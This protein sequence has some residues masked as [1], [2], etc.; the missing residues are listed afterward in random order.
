M[1]VRDKAK[2][3]YESGMKYKDIAEKVDV[4]INT[5]KSW[6]NRYGWSRGAPAKKKDAT[7]RKRDASHSKKVAPN[8]I[9]KL[10]KNS[11]L[12]EKQKMFC[13]Y[14]LQR[15][16]ATWAYQKAYVTS[17]EAA[18]ANGPRLIGNDR[19]KNQLNS[20]KKQLHSEM[21]VEIEDIINEYTKQSFASLGDVLDYKVHKELVMDMEGNVF[22]D[23]D[24]NPVERH[25]TDIY[26]KPSDQID[27][28]VVQDIHKGKDG[29][30]VKLYDKQKALDSLL[31]Y[32]KDDKDVSK[33]KSRKINAEADIAQ[34]KA[35][36]LS[37]GTDQ[38]MDS[39]DKLLSTIEVEVK[40]D[41]ESS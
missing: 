4:P 34:S 16:N 37:N 17:Y 25:V 3:F 22:L 18:L 40:H 23:T 13:L 19:I 20:L 2:E 41:G 1:D 21:Y 10:E 29:L 33:A 5:I 24:D 12:T 15:F 27:W 14:Y 39:I 35:A 30:V 11:K 31:K 38:Q 8:V 9:D 7:K 36:E 28:S 32:F 26:L 6:R